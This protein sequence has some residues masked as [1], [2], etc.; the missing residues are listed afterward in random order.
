MNCEIL[1]VG[2]PFE[3]TIGRLGLPFLCILGR[4]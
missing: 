2:V 3:N 1:F 4:R